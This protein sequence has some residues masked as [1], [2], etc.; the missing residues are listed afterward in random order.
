MDIALKESIDDIILK[1]DTVA[2][3]LKAAVFHIHSAREILSQYNGH[4]LS[5]EINNI[6]SSFKRKEEMDDALRPYLDQIFWRWILKAS[7][8]PQFLSRERREEIEKMLGYDWFSNSS[9]IPEFSIVSI[10]SFV[11]EA[12]INALPEYENEVRGMFNRLSKHHKTNSGFSFG[13]KL[14]FK[15]IFP[16][17]KY[18]CTVH[19]WTVTELYDFERI[20]DI[21]E[22]RVPEH[23]KYAAKLYSLVSGAKNYSGWKYM[24]GET[25]S[26]RFKLFKNGNGHFW[27]KNPETVER[28]NQ[29]IA[30][31]NERS[32]GVSPR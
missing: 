3:H 24:E 32:L 10:E 6:L 9:K 22:G 17:D 15:G 16:T 28:L 29:I 31:G 11:S 19:S 25:D 13:S 20:I 27:I 4:L 12:A 23:N 8:I 26:I 1:K 7:S 5:N 21:A 30:K 14:I 2:A 18:G